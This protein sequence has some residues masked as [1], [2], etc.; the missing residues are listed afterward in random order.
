MIVGWLMWGFN[1]LP[2]AMVIMETGPWFKVSFDRLDK[3]GIKLATPADLRFC[4]RIA[5]NLVFSWH[6]SFCSLT[7]VL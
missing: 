6:G 5:K 3:P 7:V 4:Y 1:V 2:T